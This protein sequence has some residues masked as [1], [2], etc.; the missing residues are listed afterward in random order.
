[1]L[2]SDVEQSTLLVTRL[3]V[4]YARVLDSCRTAQR[5]AWAACGGV[6]MGTEGDSFFVVFSTAGAAVRAAV[7]AQV[8]LAGIEWPN[9]EQVRVRMGIH[10]GSPWIHDD[11]YVGI[12]V[13]RAARIAAAAHGGQV[14]ISDATAKLVARQPARGRVA[15]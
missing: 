8:A 6:E 12:D 15:A 7:E 3:G 14:V 1:M 5:A 2:F 11:G 13:H 9:A 4:A 10:T